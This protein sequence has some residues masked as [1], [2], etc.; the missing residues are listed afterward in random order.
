MAFTYRL[1]GED[2]QP[3][4]PPTYRTVVPTWNPGDTIPLRQRT[5]RDG[6]AG[7]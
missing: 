2:G 4:D 7:D 6:N 1:E 5:V 3:V